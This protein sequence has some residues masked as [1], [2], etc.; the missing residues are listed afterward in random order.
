VV[1]DS[2]LSSNRIILIKIISLLS[3]VRWYNILLITA[4]QYLASIFI[5]ND[6]VL[7]K[8]VLLDV[9]MFLLALSSSFL[10]A[11]GYIINGFYDTEKDMINKPKVAMFNQIVSKPF[12][13]YC[14]FGFNF[15][16]VLLGLFVSKEIFVFNLLFSFALWIYSHKLK[17]IFFIGN[18]TATILSITP[19]FAV[20]IYYHTLTPFI[21]LYVGF[22]FLIEFTREIIKDMEAVRGDYIM[23]YKT[24]P[25]EF[26]LHKTRYLIMAIQCLTIS[27][28][29]FLYGLKGF[30]TIMLYFLFS[31]VMILIT[32]FMLFMKSNRINL[33]AINTIYKLIILSGIASIVLF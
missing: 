1:T 6:P 3:L 16:G 11:G 27:I 17:K 33:R 5:I 25:V 19:F 9:N 8:S 10:I 18:T 30:S 32:F 7:W 23:G 22:I 2:P 15:T 4:A 29:F 21:M 12:R 14:Y 31:A 28:P 24:L 26:G 20:S 13:L